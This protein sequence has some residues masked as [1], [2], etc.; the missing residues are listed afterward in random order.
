MT[1]DVQTLS[2]LDTHDIHEG[3]PKH[4]VARLS[5]ISKY[6]HEFINSASKLLYRGGLP[7]VLQSLISKILP[8]FVHIRD[9]VSSIPFTPRDSSDSHL[10]KDV[11][12]L[13]E[14]TKYHQFMIRCVTTDFKL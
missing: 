8:S 2:N 7:N 10:F 1:L 12:L 3:I 9:T 4:V 11:V 13:C 6:H 5:G 14:I